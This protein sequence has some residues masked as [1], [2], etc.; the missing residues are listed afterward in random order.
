M[1]DLYKFI[2]WRIQFINT[3]DD[4]IIKISNQLALKKGTKQATVADI[5]KNTARIRRKKH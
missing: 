4:E 3:P 2:L 5:K 1:T